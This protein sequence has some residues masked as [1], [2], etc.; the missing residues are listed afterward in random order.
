[1]NKL[2]LYYPRIKENEDSVQLYMGLPLS[3][4]SLVSQFQ[5]SEYEILVIDGRTDD[6]NKMNLKEWLDSDVVCIGVSA[7]TSYQI[8]DGLEFTKLV[9]GYNNK[10][11]VVWGGWHP[12]LMPEQTIKNELIDIVV[13]GQGEI[14]FR[15]LVRVLAEGS[16]LKSVPNI[17]YK[18]SNSKIVMNEKKP[19]LDLVLTNP[20]EQSYSYVNMERYVEPLWGSTRVIGYESS[21]GCPW[22]CSFCSIGSVYKKR[23]NALPAERVVDGVE[24]LKTHYQ[25]DAVHFYDNNFFVDMKRAQNIS[26][27]FKHRKLQIKW[28]GTTTVEQFNSFSAGYIE[29]LKESGFFRIIV[30]IESGDKDVLEKINKKHNNQQ[31]LEL[32]KKCKE[33]G[34]MASLSFMVG[35]PWNPEKDFLETISL[36]E[37]ILK[38]NQ[39]TEI[40]LFVF[41]PYL[42]TEMYNIAKEYGMKFPDSLEGWAAYTYENVNTPWISEKLAR[43]INRYISFFGTK[44]MSAEVAGFLKG[45]KENESR[46]AG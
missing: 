25:V 15:A 35:F 20:I 28:D 13:T 2:L 40:L 14:A 3:V 43:K 7:M 5:P 22:S 11:T 36:I 32:A 31:V 18:D 1:M 17:L 37:E 23:W 16:D 10:I 42:G 12:S 38:I 41:S 45:G 9:K 21:R 46:T 27:M 26:S 33:S 29:S 8:Q 39:N 24:Y 19:Y 34:I 6:W 44:S 30:G 4:L